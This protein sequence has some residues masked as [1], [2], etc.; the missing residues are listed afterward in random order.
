MMGYAIRDARS[1]HC[2]LALEEA[3]VTQCHNR[4]ARKAIA[5]AGVWKV[6]AYLRGKKPVTEYHVVPKVGE[7]TPAFDA[8]QRQ[9]F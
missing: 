5:G 7:P 6:C 1:G 9:S 8:H 4:A 3:L 2:D